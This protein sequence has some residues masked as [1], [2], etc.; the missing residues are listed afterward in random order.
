MWLSQKRN[1]NKKGLSFFLFPF[2]EDFTGDGN[3]SGLPVFNFCLSISLEMTCKICC[4]GSFL[5]YRKDAVHMD[6]VF[7]TAWQLVPGDAC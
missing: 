2:S 5:P 7:H 4:F 1:F 6:Y 3:I